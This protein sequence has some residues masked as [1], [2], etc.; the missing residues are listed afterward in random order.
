MFG[1]DLKQSLEGNLRLWIHLS[2]N[3]KENKWVKHSIQ[4]GNTKEGSNADLDRNQWN[5]THTHTN[6][7]EKLALRKSL[8]YMFFWPRLTRGKGE[9]ANVRNT[10]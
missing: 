3:K 4:N 8:R 10:K 2:E 7:D 5:G 9:G 6:G 1:M